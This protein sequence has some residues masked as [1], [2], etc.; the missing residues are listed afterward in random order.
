ME[1]KFIKD[2]AHHHRK[3]LLIT[4]LLVLI[5]K[6]GE[7]SIP[8]FLGLSID[9]LIKQHYFPLF[10]LVSVYM[11]WVIVGTIRH[12]Y[13]TRTY[14]NIYN[15]VVLDIIDN[16]KDQNTSKT[17]A[18]TNLI[19]E[20]VDF[21]EFDMVY[22]VTAIINIIGSIAM[23]YLYSLNV[24]LLCLGVMVPVIYLSKKYGGIMRSLS[25]RR[26]SELEKQVDVIS[27]GN[28]DETK[29]H[30][31][32][33]RIIQIKISNKEA[34]NYWQL[35]LIS[36]LL[37]VGSLLIMSLKGA[38]MAGVLVAMWSYLLTF[39][40]A[41]EIIPYAIQKWSNLRDIIARIHFK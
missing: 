32:I 39:L 16:D 21:M 27:K 8:F 1:V 11:T 13:D 6:I 25:H 7:L 2:I 18:H 28:M 36:L 19:R 12:R 35:Q 31:G 15:Q 17:C 41:L 14:T 4:Y 30:F 40:S 20:I 34:T 26:N 22:I 10:Y 3:K 29:S 9:G 24:A 23:I 5:E 37:L 33:L 38:I